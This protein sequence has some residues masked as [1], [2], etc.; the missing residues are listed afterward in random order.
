MK[1]LSGGMCVSLNYPMVGVG[2]VK[3]FDVNLRLLQKSHA[4]L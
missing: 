4:M 2:W 1:N 3:K